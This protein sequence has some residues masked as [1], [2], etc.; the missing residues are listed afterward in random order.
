MPM[1]GF[2]YYMTPIPDMTA[3][4]LSSTMPIAG[5]PDKPSEK[6]LDFQHQ[7]NMLYHPMNPFS[8]LR[9]AMMV[10]SSLPAVSFNGSPTFRSPKA[11]SNAKDFN[12]EA[13]VKPSD[14]GFDRKMKMFTFPEL[15]IDDVCRQN[16]RKAISIANRLVKRRN[17]ETLKRIMDFVLRSK[18]L[19]GI[20]EV[21]L[22]RTLKRKMVDLLKQYTVLNEENVKIEG[23][24]R[25]IEKD[26]VAFEEDVSFEEDQ[27][28]ELTQAVQ[29][30]DDPAEE[31]G[32]DFEALMPGGHQIM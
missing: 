1:G 32:P 27:E 25:L 4:D 14:T 3:K 21:N 7:V 22:S 17:S 13:R 29:E 28:D 24:K 26:G 5:I 12:D 23:E 31:V 19:M 9:M 16:Q 30:F 6:D 8:P 11:K 18:F 2:P 10:S 20:T 15:Q